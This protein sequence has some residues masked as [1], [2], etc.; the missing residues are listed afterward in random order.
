MYVCYF[1]TQKLLYRFGWTFIHLLILTWNKKKK[2][3]ILK[4]YVFSRKRIKLPH[5]AWK[6]K[7]TF[8]SLLLVTIS[9]HAKIVQKCDFYVKDRNSCSNLFLRYVYVQ[10]KHDRQNH[11]MLPKL[12]TWKRYPIL[13]HCFNY[14]KDFQYWGQNKS[15]FY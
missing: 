13:D 11:A 6:I 2:I 3:F 8:P 15:T 14:C 4:H 10:L 1:F 7:E 5:I 9:H 12:F